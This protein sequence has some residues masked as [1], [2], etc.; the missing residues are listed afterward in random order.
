MYVSEK[1]IKGVCL[2]ESIREAN[3]L[4]GDRAGVRRIAAHIGINRL[5][6]YAKYR[7]EGIATRLL[8]AIR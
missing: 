5:W 7:R 6:V 3:R 2:A 4:E 8:D 1:Q